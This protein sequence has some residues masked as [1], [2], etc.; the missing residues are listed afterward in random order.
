MSNIHSN[1]YTLRKQKKMTLEELGNKVGVTKQ[2]M[3]RYESGEIK[4][5]PY[6]KIVSLA[7]AL[8]VTP[9]ELMGWSATPSEEDNL[10]PGMAHTLSALTRDRVAAEHIEK[11]LQLD[12]KDKTIIY[13]MIDTLFEKRQ[14]NLISKQ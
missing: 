3:Q 13:S 14:T 1:I 2:T 4:S 12:E 7:D 6:D 5:I 8:D 9:T 11:V 10:T